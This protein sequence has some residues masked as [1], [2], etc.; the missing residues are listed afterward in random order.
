M[1]N[2][3]KLK[4]DNQ[5]FYIFNSL[6]LLFNLSLFFRYGTVQGGLVQILFPFFISLYGSRRSPVIWIHEN[7]TGRICS[8]FLLDQENNFVW[9]GKKYTFYTDLTVVWRVL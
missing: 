2:L 4:H 5:M 7:C 8:H 6:R 9:N 3:E 1:E